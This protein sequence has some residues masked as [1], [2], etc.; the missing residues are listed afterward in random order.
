VHNFINSTAAS[1]YFSS[2]PLRSDIAENQQATL[3]DQPALERIELK[4]CS[5]RRV[6]CRDRRMNPAAD[7][8]ISSHGHFSWPAC[9]DQII[10]DSIDDIFMKRAV[11]TKRPEIEF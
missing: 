3:L 10:E 2:K 1:R 11:L 4:R 7:I 8:E 6:T 9:L 5:G